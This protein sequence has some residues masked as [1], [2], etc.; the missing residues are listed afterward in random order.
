MNLMPLTRPDGAEIKVNVDQI[1]I[2]APNDGE[3][4]ADVKSV[5]LMSSGLRYGVKETMDEIWGLI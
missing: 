5:L 1:S 2:I 4:D 3:F